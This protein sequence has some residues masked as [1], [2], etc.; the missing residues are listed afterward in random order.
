[1]FIQEKQDRYQRIQEDILHK[2]LYLLSKIGELSSR[3]S[4]FRFVNLSGLFRPT[5]RR[6]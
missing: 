1:M 4:L 5:A 2:I 6:F 3:E